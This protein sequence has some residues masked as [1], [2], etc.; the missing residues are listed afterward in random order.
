M[1][2]SVI[3]H[4]VQRSI[5]HESV[6]GDP[7]AAV[8]ARPG[9]RHGRLVAVPRGAVPPADPIGSSNAHHLNFGMTIDLD[10]VDGL[11]DVAEIGEAILGLQGKVW[12]Y[13]LLNA[14]AKRDSLPDRLVQPPCE[15]A[16]RVRSPRA[17]VRVE[18]CYAQIVEIEPGVA[19]QSINQC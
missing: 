9:P 12:R 2:A 15:A 17:V 5:L 4:G 13:L 10:R 1:K 11:I 8:E 7:G 3:V 14:A 16:A 18:R 19:Q 6:D